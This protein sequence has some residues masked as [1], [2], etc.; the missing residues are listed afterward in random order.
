MKLKKILI[1]LL[2]FSTMVSSLTLQSFAIEV[3][4]N[5]GLIAHYDFDH[6]L[7]NQVDNSTYESMIVGDGVS[8]VDNGGID[9]GALSFL[10]QTNSYL[11]IENMINAS[12]QSYTLATWVK[13]SEGNSDGTNKVS[14]FQQDGSGRTMLYTTPNYNYGTYLTGSDA[15]CTKTVK[16]DEWHHIAITW[17]HSSK[18]MEFYINGELASTSTLT[19]NPA[20][21]TTSLLIGGHKNGNVSNAMKGYVDELRVYNQVVDATQIK[22]VYEL[23][24]ER[25][26]LNRLEAV[27]DQAEA[28]SGGSEKMQEALDEAI[29][30]GL[31]VLQKDNPTVQEVEE[32]I[33][34]LQDCMSA[35]EKT[36]AAKITV[37]TDDVLRELSDAMFGINHRYHNDGYGTWETKNDEINKY[38]NDYVEEA[39]F[40]S[41]RYPGGTVSNLFEWKKTIGTNR[42]ATINGSTFFSDAGA[43]PIEPHFGIDE[44]MTWIRDEINSEPIYVYGIGKGSASD[45]ADL[46]EYLNAKA[47]GNATNPNGGIDWAEIRKENGHAEPY[48][49]TMFEI[50]NEV[51]QWGQTYWLDGRGNRSVHDAF[52]NGGVMTFADNTRVVEEEDW[53]K[54]ASYSDG[55]KNQIKYTT[56]APLVKG[57]VTVTVGNDVYEIVDSFEG[58]GQTNVC[59]VDYETGKIT[60]GDGVNGNIPADG[61]QIK[62]G[63]QTNQ[64][65]FV[66]IRNAMKEVAQQIGIEINVLS[67]I[68]HTQANNFISLMNQQNMN[69]LYDGMSIHPYSGTFANADDELFYEK[70]LGRTLQQNVPNVTH[71]YDKMKEVTGEE[72]IVAVSEF[73]IFRYTNAFVKSLGHAI[74]IANEMI[75]YV[76][77]GAEYLDKHCLVD[78][79]SGDGAG[80]DA[81]GPVGQCV[82]QSV[83]Q[84]DGTYKYVSTPSAKMF[85][86]FNHMT[87]TKQVA[88]NIEGNKTFYTHESQ[89][90]VPE[91]NVITTVDEKG[92]TYITVVNNKKS[93]NNISIDIDGL[94]LTGRLVEVWSVGNDDVNAE[95]TLENP[96]YVDI[97]RETYINDNQVITY[98]LPSTSITSF[99]VSSQ[100]DT[101]QLETRIEKIEKDD[102]SLYTKETWASLKTTL[103]EAKEV[104]NNALQDKN[105]LQQQININYALQQLN[106][107]YASLVKKNLISE[108]EIID[109]SSISVTS[110]NYQPDNATEGNPDY[111]LDGNTGTIWHTQWKDTSR[112]THYLEFNLNQVTELNSVRIMQRSGV[113]G[114]IKTFDLYVKETNDGEW[115]KVVD[116]GILNNST[117]WQ[118]ISFEP[119]KAQYIKLHV[120]D[121]E[122]TSAAKYGAVA[123]VR[124][125]KPMVLEEPVN[126]DA[127]NAK[128]AELENTKADAYTKESYDV[129]KAALDTAKAVLADEQAN[130]DAVDTVL[131]VLE[132]AYK[133]LVKKPALKPFPFTDV[134][135]K[136][137]YYGV[138]NEAYQLGLMTGATETLFKPNAN[139]N[140]GMVAIVFHRM[141]GSKKVEY[142]SIFPDVAN[143]QYYTTSVLWAKQTGVINGYKDGTFKPLR[144]VSR[145]EMATMIYNFARYK[146]LDMSASKDITYFDDY[147]KITPYAVGPLQWAVEKGLMSGKDNGTRLD[148]LG[149]ATRAECSKMLVQAYKVI[150]K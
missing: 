99:K 136:Q 26:D 135:N 60:F 110:P 148:P 9:Q 144:N 29:A 93:E 76:D 92:Q 6:N 78:F 102:A 85:A 87:G 40:G 1:G 14:L 5:K 146:G 37:D 49:V 81:L 30:K 147:N 65:G 84:E 23:N 143:K 123:E 130:Q 35:Y 53:R 141:E 118:Q 31:A 109:P 145:E 97:E 120:T 66:A 137:W 111:V 98:T 51:G 119:V 82:I 22:A 38:F 115:I 28:L 15:T 74:Y 12:S 124:F 19:N 45:A 142:S 8:R 132:D 43:D 36:M 126:K 71:L 7:L 108:I 25:T 131:S 150:Y 57:T 107:A 21:A 67:G 33:T 61:V 122:S 86:L 52:I 105:N 113:N 100:I 41:V 13:Y 117:S 3:D 88:H 140:R 134:S 79:V 149:T 64:S 44:A 91:L 55:S 75:Y 48:N 72:K 129:F 80:A 73:G 127:L 4:V 54:T 83:I 58:K 59:V 10:K 68:D 56:Y 69:D 138:I 2:A 39:S 42:K 20:N 125:T 47:D 16:V 77:S 27:I 116:Q 89:Y 17:D 70:A 50:G 114:R 139:M 101:T 128:V 104:L 18:V 106:T 63:Y 32:T 11:K 133:A 96:N 112:D 24:G 94:D 95:N 62:C 90:N 121:A 103:N 34:L 46:V